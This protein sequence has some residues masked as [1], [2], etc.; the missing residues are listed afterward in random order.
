MVDKRFLVMTQSIAVAI[1]LLAANWPEIRRFFP[2][3]YANMVIPAGIYLVVF[4]ASLSLYE[5]YIWKRHIMCLNGQW[6]YKTFKRKGSKEFEYGSFE[7]IHTPYELVIKNGKSWYFEN[8]P[9]VEEIEA[10]WESEA[11][12]YEGKKL[13]IVGKGI[14]QEEGTP[15]KFSLLQKY[16]LM[17]LNVNNQN[18]IDGVV[19]GV[20]DPEGKYAFGDTEMKKISEC[21]N[22]NAPEIAY[23]TFVLNQPLEP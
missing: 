22:E 17:R 14:T 5:K 11:I 4:K 13:W 2:F 6:I 9:D 7:F 3:P 21:P 20:A 23:Q 19:F 18:N 15:G 1:I 8:P 10:R 16:E 12:A